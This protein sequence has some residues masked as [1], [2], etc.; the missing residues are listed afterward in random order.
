MMI[1][2]FISERNIET[3]P[4][5]GHA[6]DHIIVCHRHKD[7]RN[8]ANSPWNEVIFF[9]NTEQYYFLIS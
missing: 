7:L 8:V 9:Q 2:D 4:L 1:T 3:L 5:H 6:K